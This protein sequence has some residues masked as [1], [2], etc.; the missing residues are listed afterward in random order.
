MERAEIVAAFLFV[1][2]RDQQFL[3]GWLQ[4]R[5]VVDQQ[6]ILAEKA[7]MQRPRLEAAAIAAK[8]ETT[9]DHI[10]RADDDGGPSRIKPPLG[11]VGELAPQCANR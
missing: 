5:F 1:F 11:V 6:R 2:D 10:Y 8:Q 3:K 7:G 4:V 9:A